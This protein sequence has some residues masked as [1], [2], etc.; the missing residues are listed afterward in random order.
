MLRMGQFAQFTG[1][2]RLAAASAVLAPAAAVSPAAVVAVVVPVEAQCR[3]RV[4]GLIV[5]L[6]DHA[7]RHARR[8]R[9]INGAARGWGLLHRLDDIV[10]DALIAQINQLVDLRSLSYAVGPD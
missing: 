7:G 3:A 8:G 9:G 1:R 2:S 4:T 10:T 6:D 5:M